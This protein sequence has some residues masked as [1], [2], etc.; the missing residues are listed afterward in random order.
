MAGYMMLIVKCPNVGIMIESTGILN[1]SLQ[2]NSVSA[3]KC[4]SLDVG[5]SH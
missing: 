1:L 2:V 3:A 5:L 4:P